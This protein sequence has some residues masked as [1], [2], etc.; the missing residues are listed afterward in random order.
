MGNNPKKWLWVGIILLLI[1][2][3]LITGYF[4]WQRQLH[5]IHYQ[6][7]QL[8]E[9]ISNLSRQTEQQQLTLTGLQE[10]LNTIQREFNTH[11]IQQALTE[12]NY[13][14]NLANLYLQINHNPT[15]AMQILLMAEQM[16]KT[17]ADPRLSPLIQALASDINRLKAIPVIDTGDLLLRLQLLGESINQLELIRQQIT[18]PAQ[19]NSVPQ[20]QAQN[21]HWYQRALF[22]LWS[23]LK[24][25]LV[26]RYNS[27][28]QPVLSPDQRELVRQNLE[29][30]LKEAQWAV[31][32]NKQNLY[33]QSLIRV[34]QLLLNYYP[35][36]ASR[37]NI[38]ERV[39]ELIRINIQPNMPTLNASLEAINSYL[40]P[41]TSKPSPPLGVEV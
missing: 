20:N 33:Y 12:I 17:L 37:N 35:D 16:V 24:G 15:N 1:V 6:Q 11:N 36:T 3:I 31:L 2:A 41:S 5:Q 38:V 32:L 19:I 39:N 14:I 40:T 21:Q 23:H 26:I 18:L 13:L 9:Q 25:L 8:Q 30:T 34:R 27:Q 10:K 28:T 7:S 29:F 22:S 4:Y